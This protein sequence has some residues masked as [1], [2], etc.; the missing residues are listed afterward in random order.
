[1]KA[2]TS[3]VALMFLIRNYLFKKY[4]TIFLT[5]LLHVEFL[6]I[7]NFLVKFISG[8][9]ILPLR[10]SNLLLKSFGLIQ[11]LLSLRTLLSVLLLLVVL[12]EGGK[13][14]LHLSFQCFLLRSLIK[15][16]L[17]LVFQVNSQC[18]NWWIAPSD[19]EGHQVPCGSCAVSPT[20]RFS[21]ISGHLLLHV[22]VM[23]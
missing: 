6:N 14:R 1:M 23:K 5:Q 21:V 11:T 20:S 8:R 4:K 2:M 17:L 13:L 10:K 7:F 3:Q 18:L 15:D 12:E 16:D 9:R 19:R 22:M